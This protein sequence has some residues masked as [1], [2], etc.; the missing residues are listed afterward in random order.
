M[1]LSPWVNLNDSV[2]L[3]SDILPKAEQRGTANMLFSFLMFAQLKWRSPQSL[4]SLDLLTPSTQ[5]ELGYSPVSYTKPTACTNSKIWS[6]TH[7]PSESSISALTS[8]VHHYCRS[9]TSFPPALVATQTN[10]AQVS[11]TAPGYPRERELLSL[12][13]TTAS[14]KAWISASNS[15]KTPFPPTLLFVTHIWFTAKCGRS[16]SA[17][18]A[19]LNAPPAVLS[20]PHKVKAPSTMGNA[21]AHTYPDIQTPSRLPHGDVIIQEFFLILFMT[22]AVIQKRKTHPVQT[23]HLSSTADRQ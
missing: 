20:A 2:L 14:L 9:V 16:A 7:W 12:S 22:W 1:D 3:T 6:V 15:S 11:G 10:S 8:G 19:H 18:P 23:N 4:H 17:L 21:D 5:Y 13:I